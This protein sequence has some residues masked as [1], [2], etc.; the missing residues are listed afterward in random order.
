MPFIGTTLNWAPLQIEV[1]IA[2]ITGFGFTL[3]VTLNAGPSQL[4]TLG[5][6]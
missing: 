6:T 2:E 4:E 1:L 5:I 3:M